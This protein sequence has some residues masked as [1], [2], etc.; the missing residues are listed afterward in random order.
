MKKF[1]L[2][3][4]ALLIAACNSPSTTETSEV[5]PPPN[6]S[7]TATQLPEDSPVT[8][9][10]ISSPAFTSGLPIPQRYTCDGENISPPLEWTEPPSITQSLVLIADDPDATSGTWTHWVVYNIPP[11]RLSFSEA[12]SSGSQLSDGSIQAVTSRDSRGYHGPCPP[13]GT[14]RYLFKLYALDTM[15]SLE[16]NAEVDD[17]TKAMEAHILANT[18]LM[19][20]YAR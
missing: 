17:V 12:T 10:H 9:F 13:S 1:I 5:I 19:G 18:E 20:T 7:A 16:S 8:F 11:T 4:L 6:V 14:H 15:L 2:L 3:S